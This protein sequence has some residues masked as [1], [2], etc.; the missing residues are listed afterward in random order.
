MITDNRFQPVASR[1]AS[2]MSLI[3]RLAIWIVF[4]SIFSMV[5]SR[6]VLAFTFAISLSGLFL[7]TAFDAG[8]L[9]SSSLQE[10]FDELMGTPEKEWET[11][12]RRSAW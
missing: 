12:R 9:I 2:I 7:I 8:R 5:A 10:Y 1:R 4:W 6:E 11:R 3:R